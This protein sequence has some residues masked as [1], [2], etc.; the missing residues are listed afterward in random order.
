MGSGAPPPH[1]GQLSAIARQFGIP[2]DEL[3]DLS[4]S[5]H[6][7]PPAP[8]VLAS[9]ANLLIDGR[10]LGAYPESTYRELR[11]AI[12]SYA[13]VDPKCVSVA[14]GAMALLQAALRAYGVRR[15]VTVV[16]AFGEYRCIVG[17]AYRP[18][19]VRVED[20][21]LPDGA[22]LVAELDRGSD[23][24]LLAN[25]HSP[26]GALLPRAAM[27][28]LAGET[29]ARSKL[30]IVDEAFIDWTP[31]QSMAPLAAR[32]R[33]LVVL[34]SLTKFF[35]M[36]G[37]RAGY[38]IAHPEA[39][40]ALDGCLPLWPVDALT[41]E[42]ARLQL[43]GDAAARRQATALERVWLRERLEELGLTVFDGSANFLLF[44]CRTPGSLWRDLIVKHRVVVRA[45]ETFEGLDGRYFRTA[46]RTR[47][48][49]ERLLRALSDC[50]CRIQ[51]SE[52][53][54]GGAF[55]SSST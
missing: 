43:A 21:F 51:R 47:A 31:E 7:E 49:S 12:G 55:N 44:R 34:R 17:A 50:V 38:A 23:A 28:K 19:P 52:T 29:A 37:A 41:A 54:L 2:E 15:C 10:I 30:L 9:L 6:P 13:G 4:A 39:K 35:A 8:E 18:F 16:P 45:C 14:N 22:A 53:I 32:S 24:L 1:G 42:L 26:S 27:E 11:G 5:I 33:G 40:A 3:L 25:P 36:P 48:E 20:G 46:V